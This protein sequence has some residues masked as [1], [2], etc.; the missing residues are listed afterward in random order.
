MK[1]AEDLHQL[2]IHKMTEPIIYRKRNR[3]ILA[4]TMMP[5]SIQMWKVKANGMICGL[6]RNIEL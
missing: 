4:Q 3:M 2:K 1:Q 6:L 5:M